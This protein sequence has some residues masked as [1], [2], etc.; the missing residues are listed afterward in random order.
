MQGISTQV[1]VPKNQGRLNRSSPR[2]P[3]RLTSKSGSDFCEVKRK[4]PSVKVKRLVSPCR[5]SPHGGRASPL[6]SSTSSLRTTLRRP[7]TLTL[8]NS[9]GG[10]ENYNFSMN[11]QGDGIKK[12]FAPPC[13]SF[14]RQ[15]L[16]CAPQPA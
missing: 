12:P 5:A 15:A 6:F 9:H 1:K 16:H 3:K 13:F 4:R 11:P 8:Q 7:P 10:P 14:F 2:L